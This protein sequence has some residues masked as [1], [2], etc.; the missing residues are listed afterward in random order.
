MAAMTGVVPAVLHAKAAQS[1]PVTTTLKGVIK[2]IDDSSIVVSPSTN[3]NAEVEFDL[4]SSAKREGALAAGDTVT[5][6]YYYENGKRVVTNLAGKAAA[7]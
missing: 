1:A 2:K 7:K 5:I 4:T 6:T 3:K